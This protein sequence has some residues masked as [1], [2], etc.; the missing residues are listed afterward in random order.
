MV[1]TTSA[2]KYHMS[3]LRSL[4]PFCICGGPPTYKCRRCQSK[5]YCSKTCQERDWPLHKLQCTNEQLVSSVIDNRGTA[6]ATIPGVA[7]LMKQPNW[8]RWLLVTYDSLR[9]RGGPDAEPHEYYV[10]W[11]RV[12]R[13]ETESLV[14]FVWLAQ[15]PTR[16]FMHVSKDYAANEFGVVQVPEHD[17][18]GAELLDEDCVVFDADVYQGKPARA[19][20]SLVYPLRLRRPDQHGDNDDPD[21]VAAPIPIVDW[22]LRGQN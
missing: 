1:A 13:L 17:K 3:E 19:M 5:K 2:F 8:Q 9:R 7:E 4:H 12:A 14:A 20:S 15:E 16:L 10:Y 11:L 18:G 22:D 21:W 6:A